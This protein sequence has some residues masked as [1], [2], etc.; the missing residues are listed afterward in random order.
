MSHL[1]LFMLPINVQVSV[2][3]IAVYIFPY[4][5][6]HVRTDCPKSLPLFIVISEFCFTRNFTR[7]L[8]ESGEGSWGLFISKTIITFYKVY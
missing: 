7:A 2:H 3:F 5:E 4:I 8:V 1:V 6:D